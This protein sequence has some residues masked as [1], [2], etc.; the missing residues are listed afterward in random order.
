MIHRFGDGITI[1]LAVEPDTDRLFVSTNAGVQIFDPATGLFTQYSRDADLRV[2]SLAFASDGSLWAVTWPDRRQVVRFTERARVEVMLEFESDI[3]SLAFGRAGTPLSGLLFISH[4]RGAVLDA[5]L[6]DRDSDLTM[7]DTATLRRVVVAKGGTRGDV[8]ITTSDGR[9]LLS[10]SHQ[11]DVINPVY[12]PSV[13]ATNP[14][15]EA[16]VPLPLPFISVTFDQDMFVDDPALAESVLNPD[17][18]TLGG[19]VTGAQPVQSVVYDK[20]GRTALLTFQGLLPDSFTL[21]VE[22]TVASVFG[23]TLVE[24]YTTRFSAISDLSA[25]IDIDF[26]LTRMD[27]AL[28]TVS[29]DVSLTNIG[30]TAVVLPVLLNLDPRDGYPGIP[31]DATGQTDDGRW[32]IDLSA[33]LDP[34]GRLEPGEQTTGRTISVATPD[35]RRVDF[36]AGITAGTELNRAPAFD[37]I[38]PGAATVGETFLYDANAVDPDG[39][40]VIYHLLTGP[41]GMSVDPESGLVSWDVLPDS[42]SQ[43]PVVLQAFDSRGAVALQ[44]FV[45]TVAGGNQPPSFFDIPSQV[46]GT[47]G[48]PIEFSV[49]ALDPDLDRVTVWADNLPAGASFDSQKRQFNWVP[50]YDDAGTYPDVRFFAADMFSQVSSSV[51]LLISEGRQPLSLV[52]PADRMVQEGDRV[53]FYLQADGDPSL[54]L[55]FSSEALPWGATLHPETGLFEWTPGF[56]QAGMYDVPFTVSDGVESVAVTTLFTVTNANAAPIFDPQDGWQV[57]E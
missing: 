46:E 32:L 44:R 50:G 12:A 35:R 55:A 38:P 20:D 39:Q 49:G 57:L 37:S 17:N 15:N 8:V 2:G 53:R 14:P 40:P 54:P 36:A 23:L 51:T 21:T 48:L 31:T 19:D 9:V 33:A 47:E 27:R 1:A 13:V 25:Y 29:Y 28:G 30:N 34:D 24:D 7:V 18:Y 45:L 43:T 5:A 16:I 41:D 6:I 10:Q 42:L 4:N 11:V 56:T 26:G 3:D 52:K 22:D